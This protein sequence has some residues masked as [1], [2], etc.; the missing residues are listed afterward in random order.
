MAAV[1]NIL[2]IDTCNP[3]LIRNLQNSGFHCDLLTELSITE[4]H[5]LVGNYQG[6][7]LR[8]KYPLDKN[9]LEKA[10]QLRFIGRVG[11]GLDNIDLEECRR[12]NIVCLNSPE[13][14]RDAV[15]EHAIGMLLCITNKLLTADKQVRHGQWLREDNRGIEIKGKTV[16]IIGYGNMGS[17]F[18]KRLAGFETRI[19]AYDKYKSGFGNNL[20]LETNMDQLF[21]ECD[22]VSLHIPLNNETYY[23][24]DSW[25]F[26]H[27]HKN[28]ILINTS[29]G[30]VVNT[31]DLVEALKSGK[32]TAAALD[33]LE[34]EGSS[35]EKLDIADN[36]DLQFLLNAGNTV[37]SPHI[38]GWTKESSVKLS[39]VLAAKIIDMFAK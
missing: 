9:L 31:H 37:L 5:N 1:Q 15:A 4:F 38:A 17:A 19:I 14:N 26:N 32:V 18:A 29:R 24:A 20:V 21:L 7:I 2:I 22:I 11:A 25:F 6:L 3:V 23:L 8:S 27:F 39:E 36:S 33:V 10:T 28:I 16:G 34:Y 13:G 35:F 12:R 30:K